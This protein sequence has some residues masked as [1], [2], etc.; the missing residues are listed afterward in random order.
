MKNDK[1]EPIALFGFTAYVRQGQDARTR[2]IMFAYNGGPGSASAWLHMGILGPRRA[3]LEDLANNTRGPFKL[4]DNEFSPLDRADRGADRPDRHRLLAR[5]RQSRGQAVLG[6][7]QRHP[8]RLRL[9]RALPRRVQSL[10]ESEV[11]ARR[12]L[13]RHPHRRRDLRSA[14]A[15]QRGAQRHHP[16]LAVPRFRH[17]R[18]GPVG[19]RG[20][21]QFH[22]H[23]RGDRVVPQGAQ[24]S[25]ARAAAV[26]ARSRG[27]GG[28]RLSTRA[29]QRLA[30]DGRG[31]SGGAQRTRAL[32]RA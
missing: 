2:P 9:H 4:V 32:Y 5:G 24:S 31:A 12:K 22:F 17:W 18:G 27:L 3:V 16:G 7:R 14:D 8:L 30:S 26:P 1:D 13:R 25:T 23:L 6:R 15:P 19:R 20:Q 21:R 28:L 29:L 11:R 10:G